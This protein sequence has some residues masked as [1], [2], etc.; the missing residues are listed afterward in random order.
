MLGI[1]LLL[2]GLALS[3]AQDVA[4]P[5]VNAGEAQMNSELTFESA[6]GDY[7]VITS[8]P[9]R[10]S[11]EQTA[12]TVTTS[13]EQE[14][15]V[16]GGKDVNPVSRLGVSRVLGFEAPAGR[17]RIECADRTIRAST[18]GRYQVVS[19]DGPL[20]IAVLAA[21]GAGGALLLLGAL[22]LILSYRRDAGQS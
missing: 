8:G 16:L 17:T 6:G 1:V 4:A 13:N 22:L 2:A 10:P 7:R 21:F 20:S 3:W 18:R 14:L 12:C 5:W 9:T 15:R 19:A 11:I